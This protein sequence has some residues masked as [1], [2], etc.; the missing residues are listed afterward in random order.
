M[1]GQLKAAFYQKAYMFGTPAIASNIGSFT[2]FVEAGRT[3]EIVYLPL[4]F[5]MTLDQIIKIKKNLENYSQRS[6]QFFLETFYYEIY[7]K[8][9][10][11]IINIDRA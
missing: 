4:N 11:E 5:D 2:E 7:L 10:E 3:G 8:I 6:R 9:F 1:E